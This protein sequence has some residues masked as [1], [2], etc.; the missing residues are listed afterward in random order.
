VRKYFFGIYMIVIGIGCVNGL[1]L[2]PALIGFV[3][4]TR[5]VAP[6]TSSSTSS[7]KVPKKAEV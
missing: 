6:A 3:G 7:S 2:F 1:V 5:S 4:G